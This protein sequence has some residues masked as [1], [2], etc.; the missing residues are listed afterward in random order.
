MAARTRLTEELETALIEAASNTTSMRTIALANHV[1]ENQLYA[2]L[3]RRKTFATRFYAA[4]EINRLAI[5]RLRMG[6]ALAGDAQ[7]QR[8]ILDAAPLPE[9]PEPDG[10]KGVLPKGYEAYE[11]EYPG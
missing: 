7:K 5:Q 10:G 3:R 8:R 6:E 11:E 9:P 2:W 1:T 4:F